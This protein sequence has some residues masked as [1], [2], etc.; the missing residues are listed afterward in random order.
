MARLSHGITWYSSTSVQPEGQQ[1]KEATLEVHSP[2]LKQ[3]AFF[4]YACIGHSWR[5]ACMK[6]LIIFSFQS[7]KIAIAVVEHLYTIKTMKLESYCRL[8][9]SHLAK[10]P[11]LCIHNMHGMLLITN[12]KHVYANEYKKELL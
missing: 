10:N 7:L 1:C 11:L 12:T 8:N 9:V 2:S 3:L 4:F 6:Y 5:V